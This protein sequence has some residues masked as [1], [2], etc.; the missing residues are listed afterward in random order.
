MHTDSTH[1]LLKDKHLIAI[2]LLFISL[3]GCLSIYNAKCLSPNPMYYPSRQ[4]AWIVFG[5]IL[6][7]IA[8]NIPFKFYMQHLIMLNIIFVFPLFFVLF[9]GS[10]V[11]GMDGW[12]IIFKNFFPIYIQPAEI[13]KPIYILTISSLGFYFKKEFSKIIILFLYFSLWA[14][15]IMLQPDFGTTMYYT[16]GFIAVYWI[17]GGKKT[18]LC[19]F[20]FAALILSVSFILYHPYVLTRINSFLHPL[21][22][23]QGSGW[24]LL[25]FKYAIARGG[26]SGTGLGKAYWSNGYLPLPQTDSIFASLI[27]SLGLFGVFPL[28]FGYIFLLYFTYSISHHKNSRYLIIMSCTLISCLTFQALIHISVNVGLFPV[29]GVTL[30]L[31]SYGGSSLISTMLIF[32]ILMSLATKFSK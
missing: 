8:S 9:F 13:S 22:D 1:N 23:P 21:N 27:E 6:Y 30:P 2:I 3:L 15:P 4:M 5:I 7:Y 31:I 24:Q 11:N 12:F 17:S 16:F 19:A 14:F 25:Q 29:T 32:G 26:F 18:F 10:K 20:G 28:I